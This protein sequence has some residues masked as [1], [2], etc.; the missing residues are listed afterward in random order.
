M[1]GDIMQIGLKISQKLPLILLT[2]AI[3]CSILVETPQNQH[4]SSKLDK[5]NIL[6]SKVASKGI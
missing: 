3:V 2:I 6:L 1:W 4:A 5:K